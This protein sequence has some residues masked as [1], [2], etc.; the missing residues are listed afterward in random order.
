MLKFRAGVVIGF[1]FFICSSLFLFSDTDATKPESRLPGSS[2]KDRI[3]ILAELAGLYLTKAPKKTLEY[4]QEALELLHSF[5]DAKQQMTILNLISRANSQLGEFQLAENNALKSQAVAQKI[6]D[7]NGEADAL[8]SISRVYWE[9]GNYHQARKY[10]YDAQNFYKETG[11]QKGLA[12]TFRMLGN[13]YWRLSDIP[14]A[15]DYTLKSADIYGQLEDRRGKTVVENLIARIYSTQGQ[16]KK[17]LE[18]SFKVKQGYEALGDKNGIAISLN[19]IGNDYRRS[20][21]Y[22]EALKYLKQAS[23][24]FREMKSKRSYSY[25]LNNIGE[26]Y[27]ALRGFR[28]AQGYFSRSLKIKE[29]IEDQM[30]IAYTLINMGKTYRMLGQYKKAIQSLLRAL[31]IASEINIKKEIQKANKELAETYEALEDYSKAL[32]YYKKYKEIDDSIFNEENSKKIAELQTRYETER[33]E[34]EIALLKKDKELQQLKLLKQRN[35]INSLIIVSL[36]VLLLA[37]Y[38]HYRLKIKAARALKKEIEDR[39]RVEAELLKSQKLEAIGILAGGI[40]HDFNNLLSIIMGNL[41]LAEDEI[42]D[43]PTAAA[44][45][46]EAVEKVCDQASDLSQKLITIST[47]GGIQGQK[48]T[49]SEILKNTAEH[50]PDMKSLMGNVSISSGLKPIYGDERQLRQVIYNLLKNANQAMTEPKE[51]IIQAENII[52]DKA[53]DFSLP[54]GDYVKISI[55]DNGSGIPPEELEKIFVPYFSTK[56]NVTQK[57]RGLGL[58]LC[59]SITR[60]HNGHIDIKSEVGKGTTVELYL[61]TF[62]L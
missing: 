29:E 31:T 43:N 27:A 36:L 46:L 32:L 22:E 48:I 34:K 13:I 42:Y 7:K 38:T 9:Q 47:G 25:T 24:I 50:Y 62:E 3:E 18:Y 56:R 15:L 60:K 30:G 1:A 45:K 33:K 14:K 28:Q 44:Q 4:G 54:E 61:P 26:V 55:I 59:Y 51:V 37:L 52:L 11:N 16:Y 2:G 5:P 6:G 35:L 39:K 49:L 53:N 10:C 58:A 57:G 21:N 40:A 17:A 12:L 41:S 20:G 23:E 19:N 8:V